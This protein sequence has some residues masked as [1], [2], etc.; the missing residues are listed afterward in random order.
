MGAGL[1]LI[2]SSGLY[3]F[4]GR[5]GTS[6]G[7][8][9]FI[10]S[11]VLALTLIII[12]ILRGNFSFWLLLSFPLLAGGYSLGYGADEVGAKILRRGVY[13]SAV[14][15]AGVLCSVIWKS[16]WV[17]IPH[18]GVGFWS[19]YMGVKNPIDSPAEEFFISVLLGLGLLMHPFV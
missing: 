5:Y 10:G 18:A 12:S 13:A 16:W 11:A 15:M 8:R 19:I 7:W 9:R 1:G 2:I 14:L 6:K 4:G 17:M 3:S